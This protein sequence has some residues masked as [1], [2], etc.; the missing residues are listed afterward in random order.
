MNRFKIYKMLFLGMLLTL[1]VLVAGTVYFSCL[2]LI[3]SLGFTGNTAL[4]LTYFSSLFTCVI[5][6]VEVVFFIEKRRQVNNP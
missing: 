6:H 3:K 1:V 5:I 2:Y 4:I